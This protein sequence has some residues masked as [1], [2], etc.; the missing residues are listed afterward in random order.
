VLRPLAQMG[1]AGPDRV[2]ADRV[3]PSGSAR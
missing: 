2:D 1:S 3:G